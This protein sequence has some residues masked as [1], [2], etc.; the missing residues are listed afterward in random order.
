MNKLIKTILTAI[1]IANTGIIFAQGVVLDEIAA[2]VGDKIIL[3]SHI[4]KQRVD[5]LRQRYFTDR[6][7]R[8]EI[9][10][11]LLY[12]KLL[13]NQ[14]EIDSI[15]V[16]DRDI[17]QEVNYRLA[18]FIDQLGGEQKVE[19][20]FSKSILELKEELR[21]L[22]PDQIISRKM[23][24]EIFKSVS[25][26]PAE[27][28]RFYDEMPR[29]SIPTI[30]T[31]YELQQ[32]VKYP[33]I[34][35]TEILAVQAQLEEFKRRIGQGENFA[36][37]AVLYSA[38]NSARK[39]GEIGYVGRG[40]LVQ[41]FAE[42]A[43]KLQKGEVSRIVRTEYGYHIIQMID[44]KGEKI[45]VRHILLVPKIKIEDRMAA[46]SFLDSLRTSILNDS[47][48]F[49]EAVLKHTDDK[50][51]RNGGGL[52]VNMQ[53]GSVRF[54]QTQI[55]SEIASAIKDLPEGAIT[56]TFEDKDKNNKQVYKI[57]KVRRKIDSH[58]ANLTDDYSFIQEMALQKKQEEYIGKWVNDKKKS[59]YIRIDPSYDYCKCSFKYPWL[60]ND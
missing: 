6:D 35:D 48:K 23:Q 38:D 29:D 47:I 42:V 53:N 17:E 20:Y 11:D 34:E 56:K 44:R 22:I 21:T 31:M 28:R 14:A 10:E 32:I 45:N 5:L 33:K 18:Y 57:V 40:D 50:E 49:E 52:I 58:P 37:L 36:T 9:M 27:V 46:I 8:C 7:I 55:D 54:E 19:D 16:S 4:E 13:T 26:T 24:Q 43:F 3:K 15:E 25:I 1:I 30:P 41:E 2:L 59:T 12:T 39:G 51:T 60:Q